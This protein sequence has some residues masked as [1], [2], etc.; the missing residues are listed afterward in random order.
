MLT[1]L[2]ITIMSIVY[3]SIFDSHADYSTFRYGEDRNIHH[4]NVCIVIFGIIGFIAIF[5]SACVMLIEVQLKI[6]IGFMSATVL[7]IGAVILSQVIGLNYTYYGGAH[8]SSKYN[9]LDN[10]DFREYVTKN[11][12]IGEAEM[13][14]PENMAFQMEIT[15]ELFDDFYVDYSY[16]IQGEGKEVRWGYVPS[17]KF[18]FPTDEDFL[19]KTNPCDMN[20]ENV[21]DIDC[22]G[23]WNKEYFKEYICEKYKEVRDAPNET[24]TVSFM[25]DLGAQSRKY[26]GLYSKAAYFTHN[27]VFIIIETVCFIILIMMFLVT[28]K[29]CIKPDIDEE[30]NEGS[31][32][33][34]SEIAKPVN[35]KP[36]EEAKE[37]PKE[38]PKEK[39]KEEAKEAPKEKPKE[40]PKETPKEQSEEQTESENVTEEEYEEEEEIEEEYEEDRKSVV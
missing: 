33:S 27:L 16:M 32:V 2:L 19:N 25:K 18:G 14:L 26:D 3:N 23:A 9:Y 36:K 22:I 5:L 8:I 10:D 35:E 1:L 21:T 31:D 29:K 20:F 38:Q 12:F 37:K 40:Q 15:K 39:P 13:K 11:Y 24:D 28:S 30:D 34:L 6:Q 4:V 17:C 7:L